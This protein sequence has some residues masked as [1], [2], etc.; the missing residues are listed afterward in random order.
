MASFTG[1]K[2]SLQKYKEAL[3]GAYISC[4]YEGLIS[5][6]GAGFVL[7]LSY[8]S[9]AF[10]LWNGSKLITNNGY[11]GGDIISVLFSVVLGA[12]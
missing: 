6:F 5:G 1:E 2:L 10:G 12:V 8:S 7:F 3:N 9:Y 11:T 4:I